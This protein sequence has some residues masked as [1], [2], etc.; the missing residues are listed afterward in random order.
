MKLIKNKL[1]NVGIVLEI[2]HYQTNTTLLAF[3]VDIM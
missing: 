1:N 2:R 3:H